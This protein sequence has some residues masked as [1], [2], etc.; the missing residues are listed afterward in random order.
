MDLKVTYHLSLLA[1]YKPFTGVTNELL[2]LMCVIMFAGN[3]CEVLQKLELV[4]KARR[5][6]NSHTLLKNPYSS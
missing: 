1:S 2:F 5:Y 6:R 3:I 4:N